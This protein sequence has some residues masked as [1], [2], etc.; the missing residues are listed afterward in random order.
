M[1]SAIEGDDSVQAL[2]GLVRDFGLRE[3]RPHFRD[4]E[5]AGEFP[6]ELDRKSVV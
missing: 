2:R 6:R 4:L 5:E 3:V 1:S